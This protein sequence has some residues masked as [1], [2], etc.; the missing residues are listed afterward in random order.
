VSAKGTTPVGLRDAIL[1]AMIERL[2]EHGPAG[3]HPQ[4]ICDA[5]GV[6]KALVNY[7][8]GGRDGLLG[9]AMAVGYERYV[10][11]LWRAAEGA[12][13]D[14][15]ARLLAWVNRQIDW[16][17]E[18]VGLAAALNFP[19]HSAVADAELDD[20]VTRRLTDAGARNFA[21]LV[22]L[23]SEAAAV[24]RGATSPPDP[25]RDGLDAALIGWLTL[26]M[27][28]WHAGRHLPTQDLHRDYFP[29]AKD[30][31]RERIEELLG[32]RP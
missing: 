8:F 18:N 14:P 10:D 25:A 28:V 16:T 17:A 9:E 13:P 11:E 30:Y 19:N 12:G 26:G 29:I 6:S 27:S 24:R 20:G 1:E 2:A 31:V 21:N 23:V 22:A 4:A 15:T 32:P 3:V 5:L 7:H